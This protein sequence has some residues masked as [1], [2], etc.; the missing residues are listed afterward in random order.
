MFSSRKHRVTFLPSFFK[1]R[2][3]LGWDVH[4]REVTAYRKLD[5]AINLQ[6]FHSLF[7]SNE[8]LSIEG[9]KENR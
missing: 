3:P 1:E 8:R 4:H 5:L 2:N 6:F 9:K 7:V